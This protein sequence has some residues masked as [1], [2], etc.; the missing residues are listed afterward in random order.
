[1]MFFKGGPEEKPKGKPNV[2]STPRP[3]DPI[4]EY[5]GSHAPNDE[6]YD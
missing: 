5:G 4:S 3:P 2:V 1:M 6:E